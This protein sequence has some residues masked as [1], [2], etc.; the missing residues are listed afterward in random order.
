MN[1]MLEAYLLNHAPSPLRNTPEQWTSK[2]PGELTQE[3]MKKTNL[4]RQA[5]STS[6]HSE[7]G[8]TKD[9]LRLRNCDRS[10]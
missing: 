3:E 5:G 7:T 2:T 1:V 9:L 8:R 4:L 10:N 6:T